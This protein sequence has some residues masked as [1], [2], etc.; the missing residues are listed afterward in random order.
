MRPTRTVAAALLFLLP[1]ACGDDGG[2]DV[3]AGTAGDTDDEEVAPVDGE[4][5]GGE[6]GL[7]IE[8][9]FV[10]GFVPAGFDFRNLP[11]AVVYE[12]GTVIAP[13]AVAAIFPGPAVLPLFSGSVD[14]GALDDL[15]QAAAEAG[16]VGAS[17]DVGRAE[18][19]PIADAAS[20]RVTVVVDGEARVVEAYALDIGGADLG[21]TGLDDAQLAARAA[22]ADFVAAVSEVTTRVATEPMPVERYRALGLPAIDASALDPAGPQPSELA[23][24]AGLPAPEEGVCVAVTGEGVAALETALD[25]ANDQTQWVVG[26]QVLTL[27]IRAV[28]PHEP[29]CPEDAG[30]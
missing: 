3:D 20:T 21:Q 4:P 1:I 8:V 15:L 9:A 27:A 19:L 22:L 12:D 30:G 18:D 11:S 5:G 16:L 23:W 14:E 10:G 13:G 2:D 29:D 6:G 7:F 26:D 25:Q 28:L 24:P 17:P